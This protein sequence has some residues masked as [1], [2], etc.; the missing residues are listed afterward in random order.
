M[1]KSCRSDRRSGILKCL[2]QGAALLLVLLCVQACNPR[3]KSEIKNQPVKEVYYCPMHPEVQQDKPGKCDK[4]GGMELI[5]KEPN[6]SMKNVLQPVNS[7]VLS[8]IKTI[9]PQKRQMTAQI[10]ADGYIDY[11]ERT[12]QSIASRFDGRIERLYVKY[13]YQPVYKGQK[14]FDIYSPE[15]V[16]AQDNLLYLLNNSRE[17]RELIKAATEKLKILGMKDEQIAEISASR[18]VQHSVPVFSKWDGHIHQME[19]NSISNGSSSRDMGTATDQGNFQ[20]SNSTVAPAVS[21]QPLSV[22]EGMYVTR[23]QTVFNVVNGHDI[24]IKFQIK[25]TDM[26][27]IKV[28]QPVQFEVDETPRMPM[29]GVINFIDPFFQ[30]GNRTLV[31]RVHIDNAEHKHKVGALVKGHI[32][33]GTVEGLWVPSS[34]VVYLGR[35]QVVWLKLDNR[36]VARQ[37][38]TGVA[39]TGWVEIKDG[40]TESDQVAMEAHFLADSEGFIKVDENEE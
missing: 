16:T 31:A 13:N 32:S 39:T 7:T 12:Q 1:K 4:C 26:S 6:D 15:L 27:K 14:V 21:T 36:F 33:V 2:I 17:E 24:V 29:S 30:K 40:I 23:G 10:D 5:K 25:G 3:R 18:R 35:N 34:A 38:V 19:I 28:G 37:V 8:N 9:A 22:K 11:D 20:Q